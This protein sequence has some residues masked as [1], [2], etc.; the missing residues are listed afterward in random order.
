M[1]I[2]A[3]EILSRG[4]KDK[5]DEEIIRTMGAK[6]G[7][8]ALTFCHRLEKDIGKTDSEKTLIENIVSMMNLGD[9][10]D[11]KSTARLIT[12]LNQICILS[13]EH[14]M[15]NST[16]AFMHA[17]SSLADPLSS[18]IAAVAAGNGPLHVGAIDMAYKSFERV[19]VP[20]RVPALIEKV[21]A[22]KERLFGYGHRL[23]RTDDPRAKY[24]RAMLN[25]LAQDPD[26]V[27]T[28]EIDVALTIDRVAREDEYFLSR[29][30]CV[31]ADLFSSLVIVGL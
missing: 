17:A 4:D 31:N 15:T 6:A 27:L 8:T 18:F 21:K 7:A 12:Y 13:A 24:Y 19:G 16:A 23:Y 26:V 1:P 20:E 9:A 30:L 11:P 29:N 22:G 5:V 3:G 2:H 28:K 10:Q 14:G 25:D